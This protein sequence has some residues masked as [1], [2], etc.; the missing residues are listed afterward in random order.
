M[1]AASGEEPARERLNRSILSA[2]EDVS[3]LG[4]ALEAFRLDLLKTAE[5]GLGPETRGGLGASDVVQETFAVAR[6]K[7]GDFRGTTVGEWRGWLHGILRS[8]LSRT[9]RRKNSPAQQGISWFDQLSTPS[10]SPSDEARRAELRRALEAAIGRLP[11]HYRNVVRWRIEERL[12]HREVAERLGDGA[13][14]E[15]ARGFWTRALK[16]LNTDLVAFDESR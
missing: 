13:T 12:T 3:A 1:A 15:A 4:E 10:S 8:R 11:E 16:R 14:E 7:V 9:R 6:R 2:R 5:K